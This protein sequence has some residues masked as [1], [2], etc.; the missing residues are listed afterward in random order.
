M[1][2]LKFI[3]VFGLRDQNVLEKLNIPKVDDEVFISNN[4]DKQ[5]FKTVKLKGTT[6]ESDHIHFCSQVG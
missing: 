5:P 6:E 2:D 3:E 1:Y 4:K